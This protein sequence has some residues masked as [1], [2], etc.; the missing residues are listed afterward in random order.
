[1]HFIILGIQV[2]FNNGLETTPK[3][4]TSEDWETFE[5]HLDGGEVITKIDVMSG[6]CIDSLYSCIDS[7]TFHTSKARIFGP[8]GGTG[9]RFGRVNPPDSLPYLSWLK[10]VTVQSFGAPA[11]TAL[12]FGYKWYKTSEDD[13]DEYDY[14]IYDDTWLHSIDRFDNINF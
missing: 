11:I 9:G 10:F 14:D 7:L 3:G 5:F 1:M 2:F 8:Y 12:K 13:C 4:G 6:S